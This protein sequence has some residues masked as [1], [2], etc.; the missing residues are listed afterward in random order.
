MLYGFQQFWNEI[1]V[2][3][4]RD[5]TVTYLSFYVSIQK[6]NVA[7]ERQ[8]ELHNEQD[9]VHDSTDD[10]MFNKSSENEKIIIQLNN[11]LNCKTSSSVTVFEVGQLIFVRTF[12]L[13]TFFLHS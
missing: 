11:P 13:K 12:Y 1:N 2:Q 5:E 3:Y 4:F 9:P 8:M 6:H 10:K 7:N